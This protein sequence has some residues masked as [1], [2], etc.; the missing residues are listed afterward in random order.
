MLEFIPGKVFVTT[1][2]SLIFFIGYSSQFCILLPK[3]E[4]NETIYLL[5]PLNILIL[6]VFYNYYLAVVTDPGKIP[7]HWVIELVKS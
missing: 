3:Y 7:A 6:L 1:V 2:V 4:V 5:G